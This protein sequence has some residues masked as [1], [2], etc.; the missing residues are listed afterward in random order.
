MKRAWGYIRVSTEGQALDGV[1]LDA[2]RAK[3]SAWADLNGYELADIFEDAGI[4]VLNVNYFGRSATIILAGFSHNNL[5][6]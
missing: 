3:I 6:Y 1:S 2:Q 4:S 5:S